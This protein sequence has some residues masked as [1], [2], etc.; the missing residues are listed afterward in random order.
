M[1]TAY[2]SV[3]L[4]WL[5]ITRGREMKT[6]DAA[7]WFGGKRKMAD[8]LGISPSAVTQWGDTVPEVRQYQIQVLSKG[9]LKAARKDAAA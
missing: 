6:E 4:N 5:M 7:K 1:L 3:C 8:A 2:F 9:K